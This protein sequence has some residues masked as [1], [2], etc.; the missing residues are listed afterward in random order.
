PD[1][2]QPENEHSD[3]NEPLRWFS[4]TR[5]QLLAPFGTGTIDQA[6]LAVLPARFAALR[7]FALAGKVVVIDEVHSFDPYMSALIDRLVEHLIKAGGT[8]I[9][10][11]ATLTAAR[12][13]ELVKAAGAIEPPAP[14]AYPLITKVSAGAQQAEHRTQSTCSGSQIVQLRHHTLRPENEDSIWR[15]VAEKV[16]AG[17]NVVVIR[18]SVALAQ[19]TYRDLRSRLTERIPPENVGLLHSRFPQHERERNEG[20]WTERLGK[21]DSA[22]SQGSL[23]VATQIVEQSVDIDADYLVTDLAPTELILQRIG[24]L[25]RHQR[26]RPAGFEQAVCHILHPYTDWKGDT[27]TVQAALEPHHWIYPPLALWQAAETLGTHESLTLPTD[28]R[29]LLEQATKMSPGAKSGCALNRFKEGSEYDRGNRQG[30]AKSS[31]IF[32]DPKADKEGVGTRYKIKPTAQL[33]ILPAIPFE[34]G[35]AVTWQLPDGTTKRVRAGEFDYA[36]AKELH[37]LA[38]RI[39]YYLVEDQVKAA[40][41]WLRQHIDSAVIATLPEGGTEL[42]L[43]P[44]VSKTHSLHYREDIG[45][46]YQ[47]DEKLP[48]FTEPEDYWF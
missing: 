34:Q 7:Y 2:K 13:A 17:A 44:D 14:D 21:H 10:L 47:K 24:R 29:P 4:S 20:H 40:P 19:N 30:S 12:R 8:V 39:P 41:D 37:R 46:S 1:A 45:V 11:S 22:R 38:T 35:S 15:E 25:H 16:E 36:L 26:S 5:R 23:L 18:N 31:R 27:K 9:I 6:L 43:Y 28:I 33:I 3:V 32:S 42:K 48:E